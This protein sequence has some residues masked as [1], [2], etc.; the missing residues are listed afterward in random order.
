MACDCFRL[1]VYSKDKP[2]RMDVQKLE[3]VMGDSTYI[4]MMFECSTAVKL[5]RQRHTV[6][7]HELKCD[8][9]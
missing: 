5:L 7:A 9:S 6:L 3:T 8:E 1:R 2:N 4:A